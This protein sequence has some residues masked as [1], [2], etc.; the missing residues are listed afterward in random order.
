MP[1]TIQINSRGNMILP[2]ILR[3]RLGLDKGGV[4]LAEGYSEGAILRPA[5][6]FPVEIYSDVRVAEF[7]EEE[8]ALK[9]N[10]TRKSRQS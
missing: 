10:M 3:R 4:V 2:T 9:T 8:N 5:V 7:D 1:I 6:A